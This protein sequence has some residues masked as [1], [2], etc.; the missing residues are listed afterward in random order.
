MTYAE[1]SLSLARSLARLL[2]LGS[3]DLDVVGFEQALLARSAVLD[4]ASDVHAQVAGTRWPVAGAG[5]VE[6]DPVAALGR[7]LAYRKRGPATGHAPTQVLAVA[8]R[9]AAGREWARAARHALV[10]G[11][12][13]RTAAPHRWQ[14]TSAWTAVADAAALAEATARL[15]RQLATAASRLG[16]A[17][18]SQILEQA[19][20]SGLRTV[21]A[22]VSALAR[23]GPLEGVALQR[24]PRQQ[25]RV[26][27]VQAASHLPLAQD[28]LVALLREARSVRPEHVVQ[29][30]LGQARAATVLTRVLR[31]SSPPGQ[32]G[33]HPSALAAAL[34]STA[35]HLLR[36]GAAAG[37]T[38]TLHRGDPRPVQQAGEI[39]RC[40]R[41]LDATTPSREDAEALLACGRRLPE[42]VRT[43]SL[44]T[45]REVAAGRW[46][47][48][49]QGD[50]ARW[51]AVEPGSPAPA[52]Q[53]VLMD[54][55]A[56]SRALQAVAQVPTA[57]SRLPSPQTPPVWAA[58][59][60]A[61]TD[62]D[63]ERPR[64]P[65]ARPP[66]AQPRHTRGLTP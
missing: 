41:R 29:I 3:R 27:P 24:A 65:S 26:L 62:R 4:L 40:V 57:A 20:V 46:L 37:R 18:D 61:L 6:A 50:V 56:T 14:T 23:C 60:V 5:A 45:G 48:P 58:L 47:V 25:Q 31:R 63:G 13:W 32:D 7:A 54:A 9:T 22:E 2:E 55:S 35:S 1:E 64:T 59:A 49:G 51:T 19:S 39:D 16:R 43:L 30:A 8:S 17:K 10:A 33:R 15:D 52:L 44:I 12:D 66:L 21:A 42:L 53:T 38:A 36:A 11:H 34:D 28:R